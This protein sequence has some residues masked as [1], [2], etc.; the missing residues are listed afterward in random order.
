MRIPTL[1][2]ELSI[3]IDRYLIHTESAPMRINFKNRDSI[4]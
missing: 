3:G 2:K 4:P 1:I